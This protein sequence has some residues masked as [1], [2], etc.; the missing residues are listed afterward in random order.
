M[1]QDPRA[2]DIPRMSSPGPIVY[3]YAFAQMHLNHNQNPKEELRVM[4]LKK[5]PRGITP[6]KRSKKGREK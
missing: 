5:M 1:T 2:M 4:L 6:L 3:T